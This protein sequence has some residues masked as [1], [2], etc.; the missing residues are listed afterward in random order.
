MTCEWQPQLPQ[1]NLAVAALS[2]W[3]YNYVGSLRVIASRQ[4][5]EATGIAVDPLVCASDNHRN[6]HFERIANPQKRRHGNR[7][8]SFDLLP[9]ASGES[10]GNHI[11]LAVAAP[12]AEFLDSL[13]KSFKEFRTIYHAA[14]FTFG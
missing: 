12:L 13:A 14:F 7:A 9:M 1:V 5:L 2:S 4:T 10:E 8:A 6:S 3:T 11:L